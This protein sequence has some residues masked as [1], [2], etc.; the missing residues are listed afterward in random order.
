[1]AGK[2]EGHQWGAEGLRDDREIR[3][4]AGIP[5][6]GE[7]RGVLAGVGDGRADHRAAGGGFVFNAVHNVQARTPR[8]NL[9]ALYEA[10]GEGR[11]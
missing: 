7:Q 2:Y 6:G 1:M 10:F 3:V 8:E 9:V 11:G 4:V 5:E